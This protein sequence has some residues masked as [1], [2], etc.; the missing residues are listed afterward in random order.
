MQVE[1]RAINFTAVA[2]TSFDTLAED[3]TWVLSRL[4]AI[5]IDEVVWIDLSL[6]ALGIPVARVVVPGLEGACKGT[7][8]D[9][10]PGER[11]IRSRSS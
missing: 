5:G 2:S 10:V 11:A 9:Y 1:N 7:S 3:L 8:S 6:D 4:D